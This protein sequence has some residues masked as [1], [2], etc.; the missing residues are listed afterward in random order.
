MN[1]NDWIHPIRVSEKFKEYDYHTGDD[2]ELD[3]EMVTFSYYYRPTGTIVPHT[4]KTVD[5]GDTE[6]GSTGS[7]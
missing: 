4:G 7:K 6:I 1:D 2:Y 5:W 3:G